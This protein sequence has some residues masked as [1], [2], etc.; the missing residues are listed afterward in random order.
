VLEALEDVVAA[1]RANVVTWMGAMARADA[2]R[3]QRRQGIRYRDM[4]VDAGIP[5]IAAISGAQETLNAAAARFRRATAKE[6]QAEGLTA[7]EIARLFGVS[8]QRVSSLL[9]EESDPQQ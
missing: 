8:R 2:V 1:A 3:E 4:Q 5:I 6:L 9:D 7:A